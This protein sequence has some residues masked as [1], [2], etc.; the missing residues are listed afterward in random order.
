MLRQTAALALLF[1]AGCTAT[2]NH[3]NVLL[4]EGPGGK[5]SGVVI[6]D[7]WILT[8]KHLLPIETAS[9]M[10][11]GEAIEHPT[12]DL[13]LIPCA[14]AEARG[15]LPA[16]EPPR[17]HQRVYTYSWHQADTF[18][19][20]EGFQAKQLGWMSAPVIFGCSG[21]AVVNDR[22]ELMGIIATVAFEDVIDGWGMYS[23]SHMAGYTTLNEAV[24]GW[25]GANIR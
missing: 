8:A 19:K 18:M 21:G 12:L 1:V 4:M 10:P 3:P 13:A 22:G 20:T 6:A 16:I 25:I 5:G 17:V 9:G 7:G 11:C 14:G 24:R 15:L 2:P 23:V